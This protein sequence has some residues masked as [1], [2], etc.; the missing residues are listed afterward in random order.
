MRASVVLQDAHGLL[1]Q[2][3]S[4]LV[5]IAGP[6][7]AI[8]IPLDTGI[9]SGQPLQL[10]GPVSI[11]GLGVEVW[12]PD[13]SLTG[14]ATFGVATV[15]S[16]T[17]ADGPWSDIPLAG[18]GPWAATA[19][20]GHQVPDDVPETRVEG[21][22][23]VFGGGNSDDTIFGNGSFGASEVIAFLP[24][25]IDATGGAMP[26][27]VNRAFAKAFDATTGEVVTASVAGRFSRLSIVGVMET[28][29]TTDPAKPLLIADEG[30]VSLLRL[31]TVT[32]TRAVDEWWLAAT[33]GAAEAL[34][35]TLAQAPFDR[36]DLVSATARARQLSTDPVALGIIG[37]LTLGF[38]TTGLFAI[39]G[40]TVSAGVSARQQRT[41]F[42]LLRA[43]GL[44][45]R[46]LAGSLWLE[47]G[48]IVVLGL[49]AGTGL[50]L[51]I[52]WL[53]LPFVTVTQGGITPVPSVVIEVPWDRVLALDLASAGALAVAVLV[54]GTV[55]RRLRVG[56]TL[57]MGEE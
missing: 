46:Q 21:V 31:R 54:I 28:F 13:F 26:V 56:A 17:A 9:A 43:L 36:P 53:V 35:Q 24:N 48:T 12:L 30:T 1:Y 16:G 34:A 42:A 57:R 47:H 40:M 45:G 19:S 49:L 44:S 32:P 8:V 27:I 10:D 41:E 7:T 20:Q 33:P 15:T 5:P 38:V 25:G 55:L 4:A 37:A 6:D 52:A 29:P 50:G 39:V 22:T 18:A 23:V 3:R 14:D 11:A 51:L 2:F